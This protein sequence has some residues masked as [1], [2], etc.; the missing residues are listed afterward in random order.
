M[1]V[2]EGGRPVRSGVRRGATLEGGGGGRGVEKGRTGN[3]RGGGEA[4]QLDDM[5][6]L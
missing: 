5:K 4:S 6:T 1:G 3:G 2:R